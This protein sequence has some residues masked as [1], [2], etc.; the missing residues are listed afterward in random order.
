MR[1]SPEEMLRD[2][3]V[4]LRYQARHFGEGSDSLFRIGTNK[5]VLRRD[6]S[7][8]EERSTTVAVRLEHADQFANVRR[9]SG[10]SPAR[11]SGYVSSGSLDE[12]DELAIAVNGQVWGLTRWFRD[13]ESD[14]QRFRLLVPESSFRN[15]AN[16]V[17]VFL[18]TRDGDSLRLVRVG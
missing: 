1:T 14:T 18:V 8:V 2:R 10:F 3:D 5:V 17:E 13:R 9:A 11:I 12:R 4:T 15:G 16:S 7:R 6:V